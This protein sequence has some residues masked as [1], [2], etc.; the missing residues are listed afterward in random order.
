MGKKKASKATKKFASSGQLKKVIQARHKHQQI[1]KRT[2]GR[3]GGAKDGKE[4]PENA[5]GERDKIEKSAPTKEKKSKK[6]M[7]VDDLLGAGFMDGSDDS[8]DDDDQDMAG[9]ESEEEDGEDDFHDDASFASVDDLEKEGE[10]HLME[11][12]K[13]AEKDPEF[14]KYLQENDQELLDFN[15]DKGG[16]MNSDEDEEGAEGDEDIDMEDEKMPTLTMALL[17]KWQKALLDQRSL[18]ALRK[19]LIAF[20]AAAHLN[21]DGQVLAWSIDSSSV[22]NKLVT[23]TL[24]Y[25]PVVLEHH[26]PYKTLANGKFKPPTQTP[27][28][29]TLQ[30]L[31]LAYFHNVIHILSQLTDN[32]LLQ[33]AVTESAKLIPYI[34]SSRKAVKLYLKKCLELWSSAQDSIRIAAFLAIRR[35]ASVTDESIMDNVL[36]GIYLTLIRSSKSTSVHTLPSINLMKNSASEIFCIDHSTAYQHAFGYIRQ[37]AIHLRNSMKVKTKE[38]YKQVYNWQYVHCIDFWSIVLARACDART[39]AENGGKESDLKPLIYPFVQ[40]CL[41]AIKL[42]STSRSYPF[43]LHIIRSLLHLTKHSETFIPLSPYL[44]PILTATLAPSTRAKPS[45]LRPLDLEVQIRAPQQYVKTRVYYEGILE[46]TTF[47]LAEWL[48]SPA[49]QGSI[50]FSEIVVPIV[51]LLRKALKSARTGS[52]SGAGSG[53]D[54]G[55]VKILLERIE[56]SGRWIE[57]QRKGV[58][59]APGKLEDVEE[60]E[61]VVRGKVAESALGKYVKIQNK[62]REKRRK[63]VEKARE[64]EDE[65]LDES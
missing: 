49:V 36:K 28:F 30:K 26:V 38:A 65:I 7:S 55:L 54:Q 4:E 48:A 23:T 43:H 16:D 62:T 15:L 6:G 56:E 44:V 8:E 5:D 46:E 20:R 39:Q 63:L 47:L 35:L 42:I 50:A 31:I 13:L 18:R 34:V 21:E 22:Y 53:K 25:T 33:L 60:W 57:Q 2:Q 59:F 3:R 52:G 1:R 40:V 45:T 24:R 12:S 61:R 27:K 32:D 51:V 11:L 37:L 14:Y 9:E 29:K 41:G 17:R 64:G 10:A 19:M 58:S